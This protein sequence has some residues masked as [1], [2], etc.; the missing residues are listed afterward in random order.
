MHRFRVSLII[1]FAM[2]PAFAEPITSSRV[3][4]LPAAEQSAW[5]AYLE[6]SQTNAQVDAAAVQTEVVANKMTYS[7]RAH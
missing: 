1:A 5:Q 3:T 6:R 2:S 7:L 4:E